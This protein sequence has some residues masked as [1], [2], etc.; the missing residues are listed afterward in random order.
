MEHMGAHDSPS[1]YLQVGLPE[2]N[3]ANGN[4]TSPRNDSST[5]LSSKMKRMLSSPKVTRGKA[6]PSPNRTFG[7]TLDFLNDRDKT[8]VPL[9]VSRICDYLKM[10][11]LKQE[12]LFR[13]NG[14]MKVVER[15]K[16]AFDKCGDADLEE[17][18]DVPAAASLLKMFLRELSEPVIPDNM[19]PVFIQ[20]QDQYCKEKDKAIPL[21]KELVKRMPPANAHLLKYLC[22]FMLTISN[23]SETNKMTPLALAI[24][25][26]PN[27]F[28]CGEGLEG[29]KDQAYVNAVLLALLQEHEEIFLIDNAMF[30]DSKPRSIPEKPV[31]YYDTKKMKKD[32]GSQSIP[33]PPLHLGS[34]L[35]SEDRMDKSPRRSNSARSP[36]RTTSS[37]RRSP[38]H[39]SVRAQ[40]TNSAKKRNQTEPERS[41][42]PS[43]YTHLSSPLSKQ[44]VNNTISSTVKEHLFGPGMLISS[45]ESIETNDRT[46]ESAGGDDSH[47][48]A[49]YPSVM[50]RVKKFSMDSPTHP[51]VTPTPNKKPKPSSKN[52][53]KKTRSGPTPI[54]PSMSN[55]TDKD[56]DFIQTSGRQPLQSLTHRRAPSQKRRPPSLNRRSAARESTSSDDYRE[57]RRPSAGNISNTPQ[58]GD[59]IYSIPNKNQSN[60]R[61]PT[62]PSMERLE[63]QQ[64][65][66]DQ[67]TGRNHNTMNERQE[68]EISPGELK[69]RIS[70]LKRVISNFENEFMETNGRKVH[71][72]SLSHY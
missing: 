33:E 42:S 5:S 68:H 6:A 52:S 70:S 13:V 7:V 34:N 60:R 3:H 45:T 21:F 63:L 11:G 40:R 27:I 36:K 32:G 24:V 28:R 72:L 10:H 14:N 17:T 23:G 4:V 50:E 44:L 19:Q 37:N 59:T 8:E 57:T 61:E 39:D 26:G 20:I 58:Q 49:V 12:G 9:I 48:L 54:Q 2:S 47:E 55:V 30:K 41:R 67:I 29:L 31:A 69:K 64:K 46:H 65:R 25:F 53:L 43:S 66:D 51:N 71:M 22:T 1:K 56:L 18:G 15:L 38:R 62:T 35:S 16:N